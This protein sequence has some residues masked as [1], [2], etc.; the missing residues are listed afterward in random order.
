VT[1]AFSLLQAW[2]AA[3][4]NRATSLGGSVSV[5]SGGRFS[6]LVFATGG[7]VPLGY[8]AFGF[9]LGVAA[10]LLIRRAV[11]AMA[12]TLVIFAAVQIVMP[13]WVRPHLLPSDHTV[14]AIA[15]ANPAFSDFGDGPTLTAT[16]VPGQPGA[17]ILS[18]GTVSAAGQPVTR[19]PAAC[20]PAGGFPTAAGSGG[21]GFQA[22][23]SLRC[24]AGHGIRE[25]V[26]YQPASRYWP[27]QLV[28]T[29]VF[30]ALALALAWF[31]CWRLDRRLG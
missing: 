7:V 8:A 25:A 6:P 2:W 19:L 5:F 16:V 30:L 18:S 9:A 31:C 29:G 15:S 3:P 26:S 13:L 4:I 1:E 17:W 23:V 28:E 27:L 14:A 21:S 20:A 10:G 22:G 12:L 24:L 11:P